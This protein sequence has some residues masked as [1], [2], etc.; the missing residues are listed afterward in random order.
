MDSL[1]LNLQLY[2]FQM[3]KKPE[4][5]GACGMELQD[6]LS[7]PRNPKATK[8]YTY[9]SS[10]RAS[11]PPRASAAHMS[12][13]CQSPCMHPHPKSTPSTP[14]PV[15]SPAATVPCSPA[16]SPAPSQL[17]NITETQDKRAKGQPPQDYPQS[18]EPGK[19]RFMLLIWIYS[20]KLLYFTSAV[21]RIWLQNLVC[22]HLLGLCRDCADK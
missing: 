21:D 6:I 18:M 4:D 17:P 8:S 9:G 7:E 10:N 16:I 14:C 19:I 5:H 13:C 12:P 22:L 11:S 1:C 15:P 2:L 20:L 3:Q